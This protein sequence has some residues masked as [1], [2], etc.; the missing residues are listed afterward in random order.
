M[1]FQVHSS[2]RSIELESPILVDMLQRGLLSKL[3]GMSGVARVDLVDQYGHE[4]YPILYD[5]LLEVRVIL[6][7]QI[8][9][10]LLQFALW[11]MQSFYMTPI[12]LLK[13]ANEF[14]NDSFLRLYLYRS[15]FSYSIHAICIYFELTL[16]CEFYFRLFHVFSCN[17]Y[18]R[19][20][21]C[22]MDAIQ[23]PDDDSV[24]E[25]HR[26]ALE[27]VSISAFRQRALQLDTSK[28]R[29]SSEIILV[30]RRII[31]IAFPSEGI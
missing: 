29:A 1:I 8:P 28:R 5:I 30:V 24:L 17:N 22:C 6:N 31:R 13:D 11:S 18:V 23:L 25:P 26:D 10:C 7:N 3:M 19:G 9:I 12:N 15:V 2:L 20:I 14:D 16:S 21:L 27:H 4:F